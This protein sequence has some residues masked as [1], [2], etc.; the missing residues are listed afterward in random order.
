MSDRA[1]ANARPAPSDGSA[2]P[3]TGLLGAVLLAAVALAGC[4]SN[5]SPHNEVAIAASPSA[6][7]STASAAPSQ[8]PS[9][10]PSPTPAAAG[11]AHTGKLYADR[12]NGRRVLVQVPSAA[13]QLNGKYRV[14]VALHGYNGEAQEFLRYTGLDHPRYNAV[15]V[16]APQ[17]LKSPSGGNGWNFGRTSAYPA[18]DV[19]F[20][21]AM[22]EHYKTS[23]CLQL[24]RVS[25]AGWSDGADMAVTYACHA[26]HQVGNVWAVAA[27]YAPG[28]PCA[29][30]SNVHLIHGEKDPIEPYNGGSV[31]N[32]AG[33]PHERSQSA[34]QMLDQWAR[35]QDCA[36]KRS[37]SQDHDSYT[38]SASGCINNGQVSL[39]TY[40][41]GGH[42]WPGATYAIDAQ[43]G[44]TVPGRVTDGIFG[45]AG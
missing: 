9:R 6:Q 3:R 13:S 22:L 24:D 23:L 10:A 34:P 25:V 11:C 33:V 45:T 17:G 8:V 19:A 31:D 1:D 20:I 36:P 32:R 43:Y 41:E 14:I 29:K 40:P 16:L 37:P 26:T 15:V 7:V 18:D 42:P 44:P 4:T 5:D 38:S 2:T 27:A 12:V 39:T 35:V 21:D 28:T 30:V